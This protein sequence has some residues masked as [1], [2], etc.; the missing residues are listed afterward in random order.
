MPKI[1]ALTNRTSVLGTDIV[2]VVSGS[3]TYYTLLSEIARYVRTTITA[4]TDINQLTCAATSLTFAKAYRLLGTNSS[5]TTVEHPVSA[6]G[7]SLIGMTNTAMRIALGFESI[8]N[9]TTNIYNPSEWTALTK[10][11]QFGTA[12]NYYTSIIECID[13]SPNLNVVKG[14]YYKATGDYIYLCV[15]SGTTGL[16][17]PTWETEGVETVDNTA[18]FVSARMFCITIVDSTVTLPLIGR[19]IKYKVA[20]GSKYNYGYITTLGTNRLL[21][22]G[23]GYLTTDTLDEVYIGSNSNLRHL[24]G[25]ASLDAGV[26]VVINKFPEVF[27]MGHIVG[28]DYYL[29]IGASVTS[30]TFNVKVD[31]NEIVYKVDLG[32]S[33]VGDLMSSKNT[34]IIDQVNNVLA[35]GV[36][37][38]VT[39]DPTVN[40]GDAG[41]N[42]YIRFIIVLE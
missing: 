4:I 6:D 20:G 41:M 8:Q 1:S 13:W 31:T 36:G 25:F 40:A 15:V 32:L 22:K 23:E 11:T 16:S 35:T 5:G 19:P 42:L 38:I 30:T 9:T 21:F 7:L 33:D 37:Y 14:N 17:E 27:E 18:T 39:I 29:N 24:D 10:T 28:F 12:P 26:D 3:T 34:A 2:P